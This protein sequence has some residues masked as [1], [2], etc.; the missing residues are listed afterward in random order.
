MSIAHETRSE[1]LRPRSSARKKP[2]VLLVVP[3]DHESGGVVSVV[4]HLARHLEARGHRVL[5]L[6]PG[7][8]EFVRYKRTRMGFQGVELNL[9][10]LLVPGHRLR[11][12]FAF[13]VT[14]PV[15]LFQLLRLL[16]VHNI[17]VVNLHYPLESFVYFAFC[18]WMRPIR[19]V[20]SIHGTDILL[21]KATSRWPSRTLGLVFRAAD[22]VVSP[23]GAFLRQCANA[24]A[25]FAAPRTVIHNGVD[26]AELDSQKSSDGAEA[27]SP[28]ILSVAS[29]DEWKGLDVLIRAIA[30]LRE[31]GETTRLVLAGD[32]PIRAEL[33]HLT[34]TLG[35]NHHVQFLGYQ[36]RS[37]VARLLNQ[38]SLFVLPS[39]S[40]PF[41]IV[42]IEALACGKPVIATAVGGIPEIIE[43]GRNGI[44]VQPDDPSA[45]AAAIRRLFGDANLR[46]RLGRAG[47]QRVNDAFRW[48]HMGERYARAYEE[49]LEVEA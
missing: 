33:E 25:P 39:R 13:L 42:V 34:A 3:W 14:L 15:T 2:S 18:R 48:Q 47:R 9:R 32:G 19:L 7:A 45:L 49:L 24:L 44:L 40:E 17:Q 21:W 38:C 37:S 43:D 23:S 27:Q 22:L 11:S 8:S 26:L 41:G 12:V 1:T 29:H 16:K 35:L 36:P 30:L 10:T 46:E 28:F 4:G 5:F 6:Y 20:V 31:Q